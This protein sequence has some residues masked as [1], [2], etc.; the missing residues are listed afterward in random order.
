MAERNTCFTYREVEAYE[1]G[2]R[3]GYSKCYEAMREEFE[4]AR[5][6]RPVQIIIDSPYA[7]ERAAGG[8]GE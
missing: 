5:L 6:C 1:K 8:R 2:F 3:E 4:L 7:A